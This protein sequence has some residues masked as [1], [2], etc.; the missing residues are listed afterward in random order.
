MAVSPT[1][2]PLRDR[3]Q[4][5]QSM[6]LPALHPSLTSG[7]RRQATR[8]FIALSAALPRQHTECR[9]GVTAGPG[10]ILFLTTRDRPDKSQSKPG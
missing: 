10:F 1:A 7:A 3:L 6:S 8:E 2:Q 9:G 4:A 5:P